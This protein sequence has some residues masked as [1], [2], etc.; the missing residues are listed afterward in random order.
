MPSV[1]GYLK[2]VLVP[3]Y[4]E[5]LV[6]YYKEALVPY[7]KEALVPYYKEVLVPYYKEVLVPCYKEDLVPYYKELQTLPSKNNKTD[8]VVAE[9]EPGFFSAFLEVCNSQVCAF[10]SHNQ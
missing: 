5:A 6:P 9:G 3:Y 7:Y 2:E 10:Q 4:R 8:D 1:L